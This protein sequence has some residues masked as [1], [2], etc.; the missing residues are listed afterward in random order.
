MPVDYEKIRENNLVSYGTE[1][2][3]LAQMAFADSYADRT[4]FIFELLQNAEDAIGRRGDSWNGDRT[5]SFLLSQ[6]LLRV[7][8]Y[9]EPF[10]EENV[11]GICGIGESTK[12]GD[13][14]SIGR[15]GIGF[16]SVY[17][18]TGHPE[19]HS[20]DEDFAIG[21]FVWPTATEPIQRDSD[22]TV[23]LI[24]LDRDSHLD[25]NDKIAEALA[26]LDVR[27]FL[28]LRH[29]EELKWEVEGCDS[30]HYVRE[31]KIEDEIARRV[32][33]IGHVNGLDGNE[34][35]VNE[36]WI[37][38]SREVHHDGNAT[39]QVEI[40]FNVDENTGNIRQLEE[41]KLVVYFPTVVETR[42]G[43]LVQG[44]YRT[45]PNRDNV[46]K[47]DEWNQCL[48]AQT[49]L[50]LQDSL[51]WLRDRQM[52]DADVLRC[53]PLESFPG[54][55]L[56]PLYDATK[57]SLS[58]ERLLP[59]F[60]GGY[61]AAENAELGDSEAVRGLLSE[62]Q[63]K[64]LFNRPISWLSGEFTVDRNP[65]LRR[66]LMSELDV[67]E[68]DPESILGRLDCDF[69]ENQTDIW[70]VQLYEFLAVRR[71][72]HRQCQRSPLIRLTD[73]RH[74][75]A[76]SG[77]H[78]NAYLPT[79]VETD[80][81]TVCQDVYVSQEALNFLESLGIK[82]PDIVDDVIAHVLPKYEDSD[83]VI[84][85][86]E[87]EGDINRIDN[88]YRSTDSDSQRRRIL[89]ALTVAPWVMTAD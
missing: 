4:H 59:K 43:F 27:S 44:P 86:K 35:D 13:F 1:I 51:Q 61:V 32:N 22:E 38:F 81:P 49:G 62:E 36:E 39:G 56:G 77:G 19:V 30:G 46:P 83:C 50:L 3:R 52:L 47:D 5:V 6:N 53:L 88:A 26:G 69:L 40:A 76:S 54:S 67:R 48:V 17:R 85:V 29:I 9:G 84:G 8:H 21:S 10:N 60:G 64:D 75:T 65:E 31:T 23:F 41:S 73:G 71:A 45:T 63:L 42:L 57:K 58:T 68:V 16:K 66:Y 34:S 89:D 80:F 70:I 15:F 11:R 82:R 37:V 72:L 28:F 79:T 2:G 24:P 87:Y 55:M 74:V 20:G 25:D 12:S 78:P 33:V 7:S 18:F 14:T